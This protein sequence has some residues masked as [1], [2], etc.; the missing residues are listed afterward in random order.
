MEGQKKECGLKER[1]S[2]KKRYMEE[3]W[4]IIAKVLQNLMLLVQLRA[5]T[6]ILSH[7]VPSKKL[8]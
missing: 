2:V 3:W 1:K 4:V 5:N 6:Q 7:G 8:N